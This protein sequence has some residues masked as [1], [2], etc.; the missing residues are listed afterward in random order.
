MDFV[1]SGVGFTEGEVGVGVVEGV[2]CVVESGIWSGV[3]GVH[4]G[5]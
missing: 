4:S 5:V 1:E 2:V 3:Y